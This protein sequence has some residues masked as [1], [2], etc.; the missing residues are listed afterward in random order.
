MRRFNAAERIKARR[1]RQLDRELA[2]QGVK[3][4]L[5]ELWRDAHAADSL[6][7]RMT[8]NRHQSRIRPPDHA[9]HQR[10]VRDRLHVCHAMH[11]MCNPH[12]PAEDHVFRCGIAL[13]DL[14]DL[15]LAHARL[16]VNLAPRNCAKRAE[17]LV[18]ARAS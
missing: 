5:L 16:R 7:V 14:V 15:A 11:V 17:P 1:R 2:L 8:T 10:E 18:V 9:P 3:D 12:R 13:R 4:R 6:H